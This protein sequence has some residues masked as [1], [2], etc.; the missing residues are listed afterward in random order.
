ML[1]LDSVTLGWSNGLMPRI[2]P[3]TAVAYSQSRNCAPSEP[4]TDVPSK[5]GGLPCRA[6]RG[7]CRAGLDEAGRVDAL[8]DDRQD[9][10]ALL[11]GRLGDELLGPVAEP[12]DAR[13]GVGDD[14]LVAAGVGAVAQG[15]PELEPRV[16]VVLAERAGEHAR[17]GEQPL[18][19]G[20][21]EQARREP[22]RGQR[23]VAAADVGVGEHDLLA[24]LAGERLQ[25]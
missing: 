8:D 14:E 19:V 6:R 11:A 5:L 13:A 15:R 24:G 22:E 12:D 3:A 7:G 10:H 25:R 2:F 18:D 16:V 17:V 23:A 1:S 4:E 20:P 21:G 9:A